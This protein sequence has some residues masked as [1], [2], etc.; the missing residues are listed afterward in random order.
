MNK[1][2]EKQLDTEVEFH[3]KQHVGKRNPMDRWEL[4]E[5]V[6]GNGASYPRNDNNVFDRRIRDSVERLRKR[7]LICDMGDGRG[8]YLAA[9]YGEFVEFNAKYVS[10]AYPIMQ[11]SA[12]MEKLAAAAFP[13]QYLEHKR[14]QLQP[15]LFGTMTGARS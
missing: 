11:T 3:L 5:R 7:L 14:D 8:R 9:N 1:L 2:D 6:F 15:S 4:I 12:A 13:D 10:R